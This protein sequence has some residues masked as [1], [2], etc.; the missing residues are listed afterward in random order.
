MKK[1]KK[2]D[3]PYDYR[4]ED[5]KEARRAKSWRMIKKLQKK[6]SKW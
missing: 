4:R 2:K 5:K 6:E 3:L 1:S